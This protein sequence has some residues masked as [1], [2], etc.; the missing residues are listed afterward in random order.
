MG[1]IKNDL[2]WLERE[3]RQACKRAVRKGDLA[4]TLQA[5]GQ[6]VQLEKEKRDSEQ[7]KA[8]SAPATP[9]FVVRYE[10]TEIE[11][12]PP[13]IASA[14][15]ATVHAIRQAL[16]CERLP[17]AAARNDLITRIADFFHVPREFAEFVIAE[18][19]KGQANGEW[20]AEYAQSNQKPLPESSARDSDEG[21]DGQAS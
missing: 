8:A 6:L 1:K 16:G 7:A 13:E 9:T 12:D 19:E 15:S 18:L 20:E 10:E 2:R 11:D 21:G 5:T 4:A 17:R 14:R 3:L